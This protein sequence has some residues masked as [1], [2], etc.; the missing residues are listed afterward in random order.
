MQEKYRRDYP[1]EFVI[2]KTVWAGG[3]KDQLREWID[4]PIKVVQTSG[5]ATCIARSPAFK[6]TFY[7]RVA[8]NRGDLLA[9]KKMQTYGVEEVWSIMKPNFLVSQKSDNLKEM[10]ACKYAED[11][12]VY[13]SAANCLKFPGEFFLFPYNFA[14][15][16]YAQAA[17]LA[18]F[19]EHKEVFLVGYDEVDTTGTRQQ[20][21]IDSVG[22]VFDTYP[23][24]TFTHVTNANTP[25]EWRKRINVKTMTVESYISHCDV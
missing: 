5:R 7:R 24:V 4:N 16:A 18:C 22:T 10:S 6:E 19:D 2:T 8:E 14:A 3:K 13:T 9:H 25:K 20:K 11:V 17:W 1:G 15:T 21:M 23:G 12:I